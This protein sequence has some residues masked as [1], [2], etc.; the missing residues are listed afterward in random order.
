[1]GMTDT[2]SDCAT[3]MPVEVALALIW[4]RGCLLIA[5]RRAH[6]HLG[7]YWEFPGGKLHPG[8]LP[9]EAAVREALEELGVSCRPRN[10]LPA[11]EYAYPDRAVRLHPVECDY[12]GGAPRPVEAAEFAW[13]LPRYLERYEFPPANAS[14]IAALSSADRQRE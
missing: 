11:I 14:L 2:P 1:M 6:A 8:E 13:V 3:A 7:N 4:R 10:T 12:V 9:A 5:R